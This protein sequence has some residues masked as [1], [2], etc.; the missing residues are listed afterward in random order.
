MIADGGRI[1]ENAIKR[2]EGCY[3]GK[4][5]QQPKEYDTGCNREQPILLDLF[6]G[7]QENILPAAPWD[8]PGR[9][10]PSASARF[11]RA[12]RIGVSPAL[13]IPLRL[14]IDLCRIGPQCQSHAACCSAQHQETETELPQAGHGSYPL[15]TRSAP[16]LTASLPDS[17]TFW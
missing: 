16:V 12:G 7:A 4:E 3:R 6:V 10:C 8:L 14:V 11:A 1:D 5:R 15:K 9:C 13:T 2:N 17:M